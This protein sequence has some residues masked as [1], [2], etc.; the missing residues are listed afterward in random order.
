MGRK[1]KKAVYNFHFAPLSL[2]ILYQPLRWAESSTNYI[3][4]IK[5]FFIIFVTTLEISVALQEIRWMRLVSIT[6]GQK[7]VIRKFNYNSYYLAKIQ[8]MR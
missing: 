6:V 2:S 3:D 5:L 7:C 8:S 1:A 4:S